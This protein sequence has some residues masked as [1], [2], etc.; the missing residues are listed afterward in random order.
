MKSF[1][2]VL[3]LKNDPRT[4]ETYKKYHREVWPEVVRSLKAAGISKMKIFLVG[5][6]L[7]MYYEAPDGFVPERDFQK[8][9]QVPRAQEWDRLMRTFQQKAPEAGPSDWWTAGELVYDLDWPTGK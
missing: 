5:N 9:T 8:Y 3:D 6:H 1:G 4:V 2:Q 7:F